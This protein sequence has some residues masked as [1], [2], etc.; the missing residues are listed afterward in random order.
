MRRPTPAAANK[1]AASGRLF[2]YPRR[3]TSIAQATWQ[4]NRALGPK[5]PVDALAKDNDA[6]DQS[7]AAVLDTK[8]ES[9]F[10]F[11]SCR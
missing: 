7:V 5:S 3:L 1:T 6:T 2:F 10:V 11:A 4:G 8:T 9:G